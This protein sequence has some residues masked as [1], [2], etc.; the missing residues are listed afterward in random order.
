MRTV[1]ASAFD[2]ESR[3]VW[4]ALL[5]LLLAGVMPTV[6]LR[7]DAYDY[8]VVFDI[9]QS[10]NVADYELDG[11]PVSRLVFAREAVRRALP[12]LTCGSRVGWGAFAEYRTILLLAPVE[13]CSNYD[14][15]LASLDGLDGHMRWSNASEVTKG[16]YWALRAAKE[17]E[18]R[19]DVI[20]V[21]DGH[22]APPLDPAYPPP[23]FD[24]LQQGQVHGWLIG[25]GGD[26]PRPI[27]K[28]NEEGV[29]TAY[30]RA[31]EVIQSRD[32]REHLSA[33][34]EAHL[35]ALARQ[36]GFEYARM[37]GL[38]SVGAAMR[39]PRFR[40]RMS[41]PINLYWAPTLGALLLLTLRFLPDFRRQ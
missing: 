28:V 17:V 9:T 27:P 16:V 8:I 2:R 40:R 13:V 15:L 23:M 19:P 25:A 38:A 20:F 24:D 5:L 11:V 4:L 1:L 31:F 34:R 41:T 33:L 7:R 21:T 29:A 6:N 35:Q 32:G 12:A 36:V 39:D 14:A 18:S 26:A 37:T 30:W 10:M 3:A 22:E